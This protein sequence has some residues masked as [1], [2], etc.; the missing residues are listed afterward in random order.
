[1][2]SEL[3]SFFQDVFGALA[4]KVL[5]PAS[6]PSYL[7]LHL[8]TYIHQLQVPTCISANFSLHI[9]SLVHLYYS[10][11]CANIVC[12]CV[13]FINYSNLLLLIYSYIRT[14]PEYLF[15]LDD[16][17]SCGLSPP[18]GICLVCTM[19]VYV[20]FYDGVFLQFTSLLDN[21]VNQTINQYTSRCL[22]IH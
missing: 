22:K 17:V 18:L 19:S 15:C 5:E 11:Y 2:F 3:R 14:A 16:L 1:M 12:Y 8:I 6:L 21:E 4:P 7:P 10:R 20:L 9:E 13:V